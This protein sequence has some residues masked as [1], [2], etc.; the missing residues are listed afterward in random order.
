M[1]LDA[2]H[3]AWTDFSFNNINTVGIKVKSVCICLGS[4]CLRPWTG[5]VTKWPAAS[6]TNSIVSAPPIGHLDQW[7][8]IG[9]F[10][11][12]IVT[13]SPSVLLSF[14]F[15]LLMILWGGRPLKGL[16]FYLQRLF[17]HFPSGSHHG[18]NNKY[19]CCRCQLWADT[20][21]DPLPIC[22]VNSHNNDVDD[23]AKTLAL[24]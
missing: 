5:W 4:A 10:I 2:K 22:N 13:A 11:F 23:S 16:F 3:T 15:L 19:T 18:I 6:H 12:F 7:K 8:E 21:L 9:Y 14:P 17:L 20:T 24:R 1:R